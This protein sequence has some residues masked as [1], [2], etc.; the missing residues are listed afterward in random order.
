MAS[1]IHLKYKRPLL[2][3]AFSD[4]PTRDLTDK[5]AIAVREWFDRFYDEY[6]EPS[7]TDVGRQR[8]YA[9]VVLQLSEIDKNP[10]GLIKLIME[11]DPD[12]KESDVRLAVAKLV[13]YNQ[14]VLDGK[15]ID[16]EETN[17]AASAEKAIKL[18]AA[19]GRDKLDKA[20]F[21]ED[22]DVALMKYTANI[23]KRVEWNRNTKD[24][25]GNSIYEEELRK[26]D[27]KAQEEV[28]KIVHKYLGYQES[29]LGPMW[30]AINSW[31]SVLQIVAILPLA[32]LGSIPELAGPVIA[33]KEFSAVTTAMKEIVK[34]VRNRDEARDLARDLG[35]VTSQS[36]AN[37]MM[38]QSELD[39]MDK[40]ARKITDGFFR[41][42]L[43]D[44]YTKFTREFAANMGVRFL[45]KHADPERANAFSRRY[46]SELGV[47][48]EDVK[49]WSDSNQDFS[50][51]EGKKVREA[52]Q[53]FV[54]SSTLRPNAAERPLWASDPRWAL[55]WQLKG[56]FYSYGKVMLAGARRESAKRL[57]GASSKD[58]STYA[59]LSGAA[60][61]FALMGIA[62]MPLAMVG[63]ELREYAKYG[64]AWAIPGIDHEAKDYFRTDGMSWSQYLGAAFDRS[65]AAGPITI[66]S[67]AMQAADWG[68][69]ITGAAAVVAGPTAETVTRMF[70]D[71]FGSTFENRIL[72]TGLL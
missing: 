16:I 21:L 28:K 6:I 1:W 12:A 14:A 35:V 57:E 2:S 64:L 50:T 63:M 72:P 36:V 53:R 20:G 52:L 59:A 8:D 40:Q 46:L 61:V 62:T 13:S 10:E 67:Q 7:N 43:L 31:G 49:K 23:V 44:T 47:T 4:T 18:T 32:V 22:P 58:V 29:P 19:V 17:P 26:L 5:N 11:N 66:A 38:S 60:G 39:F 70:T 54:E 56:F 48:A 41:V 55:I 27:P 25:F 34:T 45:E 24:D 33:S 42:T 37:V 71:G 30:R 15:P 9:P 3:V 65:F 51:P 68:R 69:G